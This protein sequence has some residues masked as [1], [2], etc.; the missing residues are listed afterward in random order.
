MLKEGTVQSSK[1]ATV[2][3]LLRELIATGWGTLEVIV[4]GHKVILVRKNV[5]L[6]PDQVDLDAYLKEGEKGC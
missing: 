5:T 4:N 1:K 2:P 6:K 3:E